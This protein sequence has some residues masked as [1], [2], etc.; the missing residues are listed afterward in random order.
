[1]LEHSFRLRTVPATAQQVVEAGDE[2]LVL[3]TRAAV[4][5]LRAMV[6]EV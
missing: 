5:E 1:M 3:G 2:L 4:Q 6:D